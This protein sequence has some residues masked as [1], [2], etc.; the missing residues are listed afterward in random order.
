MVTT[1]IGLRGQKVK[2]ITMLLI[3]PVYNIYLF[4]NLFITAIY[5]VVVFRRFQTTVIVL[6]LHEQK[7]E[8]SRLL[9]TLISILLPSFKQMLVLEDW[10]SINAMEWK[11]EG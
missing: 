2:H 3:Y 7:T 8:I 1:I 4:R 9:S 11:T 5:A 10:Y 6:Q